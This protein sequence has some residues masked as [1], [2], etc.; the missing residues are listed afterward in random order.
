M[1]SNITKSETLNETVS[2]SRSFVQTRT[3]TTLTSTLLSA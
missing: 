2:R 1:V 3:H